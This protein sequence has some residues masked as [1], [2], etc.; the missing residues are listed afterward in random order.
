[1]VSQIVSKKND[2]TK[3]INSKNI[4]NIDGGKK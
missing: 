2:L 4:N 1:L 3:P